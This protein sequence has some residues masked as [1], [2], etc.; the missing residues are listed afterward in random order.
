MVP[1]NSHSHL[2]W[3]CFGRC[4]CFNT[5]YFFNKFG[6]SLS[7]TQC[8]II[9][10]FKEFKDGNQDANWLG[11]TPIKNEVQNIVTNLSTILSDTDMTDT[12]TA[13]QTSIDELETANTSFKS[14]VT[15]T[16]QIN[17]PDGD[18]LC[19]TLVI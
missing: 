3:C 13:V 18:G 16:T 17:C 10:F 12:I 11:V 9:S 15:A 19:S 6:P 4:H 1:S 2:C 8:S 5:S 7:Q 14:A